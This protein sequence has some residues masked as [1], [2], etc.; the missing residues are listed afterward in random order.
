RVKVADNEYHDLLMTNFP[1]SHAR[2]AR[3]FVT[4]AKATAGAKLLILPR[5]ILDAGLFETIRMLRNVMQ[6][7]RHRA[8]SLALETYWSRVSRQWGA[9]SPIRYQ[10]RPAAGTHPPPAPKSW[11]G[12][13][14]HHEIADRLRAGNVTFNLYVQSYV[15]EKRTP[16]EDGSIEWTEEVSPPVQVATLTIPKQDLDAADGRTTERLVDQIAFNPW[17]TTDEFRPLGNMNRARKAIYGASSAHRLAYQ[18][19]ERIPLR[20]RIVGRL[21]EM[22]FGIINRFRASHRLGWHLGLLNLSAFPDLL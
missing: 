10:L 3:Q 12:D 17:H 18:F 9:P 16:I 15:D 21:N 19:R 5:L 13:Y 4:F 14:L 20:N 11:D 8:A 6:A 22:F 7:T 1:V 2:D